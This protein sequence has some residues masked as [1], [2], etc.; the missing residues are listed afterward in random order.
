MYLLLHSHEF[1]DDAEYV[2]TI[3][4]YYSLDNLQMAINYLKSKP[5]FVDMPDNFIVEEYIVD[6]NYWEEGFV[7]ANSTDFL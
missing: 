5:G 4:I 2:K 7:A 1:E 3:G 6:N